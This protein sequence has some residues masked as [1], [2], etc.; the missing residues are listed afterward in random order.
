[1][2][3]TKWAFFDA[4]DVV[5]DV[6]AVI[7]ARGSSRLAGQDV[8]KFRASCR[9]MLASN[10]LGTAATAAY[11]HLLGAFQIDNVVVDDRRAVLKAVGALASY[12]CDAPATVGLTDAGATFAVKVATG[13]A[14]DGAALSDALYAVGADRA[15]APRPARSPSSCRRDGR[16]HRRR[17]GRR[18]RRR[19]ARRAPGDRSAEIAWE[20][21]N[22]PLAAYAHVASAAPRRSSTRTCAG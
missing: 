19:R 5:E 21:Q 18:R 9:S 7:A 3:E 8:A 12:A 10:A 6:D 4:D 20:P 15:R 14:V 13:V 1:M 22:A 17:L 16:R 11:E 2:E